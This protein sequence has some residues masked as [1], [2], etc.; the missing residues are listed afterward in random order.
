MGPHDAVP[1]LLL[2]WAGSY[3]SD[4]DPHKQQD[5]A[6]A[7]ATPILAR[8][9]NF[10]PLAGLVKGVPEKNVEDREMVI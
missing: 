5:T 2:K 1:P 9:A 4:T 3:R 10:L 6:L 8:C 7:A